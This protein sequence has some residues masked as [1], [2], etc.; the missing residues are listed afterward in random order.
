MIGFNFLGRMGQLGNQMFQYASLRG[1]A[2]NN[3]YNFCIPNHQN[4]VEDI[5]GNRLHIEIFKPFVL[6]NVIDL[7]LKRLI[8]I[9]H[10]FKNLDLI[11]M[12]IYLMTVQTG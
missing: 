12:K 9:D 7:N 2:K 8:L 6:E 3:G 4:V 10:W 1:I 5:L 11:S